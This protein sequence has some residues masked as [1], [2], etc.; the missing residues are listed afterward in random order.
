LQKNLPIIFKENK[1]D[2]NLEN[3]T[4]N[5]NSNQDAANELNQS[6]EAINE[7]S[8]ATPPPMPRPDLISAPDFTADI[9]NKNQVGVA[10]DYLQTDR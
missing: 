4:E 3:Q 2:N 10:Q 1:M 9:P 6:N 5:T 7:T 8:N